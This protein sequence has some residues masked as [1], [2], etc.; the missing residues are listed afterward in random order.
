MAKVTILVN[1]LDGLDFITE[2]GKIIGELQMQ[3]IRSSNYDTY[4]SG[5]EAILKRIFQ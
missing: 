4:I 2:L 5:Y 1:G 3:R